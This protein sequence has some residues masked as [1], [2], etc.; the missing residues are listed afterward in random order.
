MAGE[1]RRRM[2]FDGMVSQLQE[3]AREIEVAH[4]TS[5]W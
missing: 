5:Y 1:G 2:K 4:G 3:I